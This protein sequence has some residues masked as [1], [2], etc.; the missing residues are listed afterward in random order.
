MTRYYTADFPQKI[1]EIQL[2]QFVLYKIQRN[3]SAISQLCNILLSRKIKNRK[4]KTSFYI[5]TSSKKFLVF[6]LVLLSEITQI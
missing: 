3:D 4:T 1:L 5:A 2:R 6:S